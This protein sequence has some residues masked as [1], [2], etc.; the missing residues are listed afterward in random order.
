MNGDTKAP[1]GPGKKPKPMG[2]WERTFHAALQGA[3]AHLDERQ[4]AVKMVQA[5]AWIADDAQQL[6]RDRAAKR[7]AAAE[8]GR[9]GQ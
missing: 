7:K 2:A 8:A 5:A 1:A 4:D 3:A 6:Q 9:G